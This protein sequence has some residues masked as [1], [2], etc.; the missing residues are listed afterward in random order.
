[1]PGYSDELTN[2]QKGSQRPFLP[3]K[4][5]PHSIDQL[6]SQNFNLNARIKIIKRK[7]NFY[8]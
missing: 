3:S 4:P 5:T 7:T 2:L 8:F 1:M 6:S